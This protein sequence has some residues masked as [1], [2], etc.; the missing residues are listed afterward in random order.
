MRKGKRPEVGPLGAAILKQ[1]AEE[2]PVCRPKGLSGQA[3]GQ[4]QGTRV[5]EHFRKS[6][7]SVKGCYVRWGRKRGLGRSRQW[8]MGDGDNGSR[9]LTGGPGVCLFSQVHG[10]WES[11]GN[12]VGQRFPAQ[13]PPPGVPTGFA[14]YP[15]GILSCLKT[16]VLSL[17]SPS[18]RLG[19]PW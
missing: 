2:T 11:Q 16:A 18:H 14:A 19:L 5:G 4:A 12:G 7:P 8:A 9:G 3:E 6:V 1:W 13:S 15:D 10:Q 17:G